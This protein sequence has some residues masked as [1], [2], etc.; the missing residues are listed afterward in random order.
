MGVNIFNIAHCSFHDGEGLRTVVY[1]KGCTLRCQWCHNPESI[2]R[3]T[4]ILYQKS[5][6]IKCGRC[7]DICPD[8]H[9]ISGDEVIYERENCS[10]CLKC[11]AVCPNEALSACGKDMTVQEVF[12]EIIKDKHYY[13]A[14]DGG[15]TFS[16]GEC[17]LYPDYLLELLKICKDAGINTAAETAFSI[18]W[19][20]IATVRNYIDTFI[21]D[22]K[23]FDSEIHKRLTGSGNQLIIS[24]IGRISR[25]HSSILI[26]I[27]LIPNANDDDENLIGTAKLINTFGSGIKTIELLKYNNMAENKYTALGRETILFSNCTQDDKIMQQ[28]YNLIKKHL[29]ADIKMIY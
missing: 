26:R 7:V 23:H 6:C 16:G 4:E 25:L 3:K 9:I 24:N 10:A 29:R 1:M 21:I 20:S 8:H 13:E 11:V 5:R 12:A 17:L 18:E 15:V 14:S 19:N 27:P 28:K 22:I 2:S